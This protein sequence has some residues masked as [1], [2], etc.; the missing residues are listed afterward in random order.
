MMW[1]D[2][3]AIFDKSF[4][5]V[6]YFAFPKFCTFRFYADLMIEVSFFLK[7]VFESICKMSAIFFRW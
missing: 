5:K 4:P 3:K 1:N 7:N 2:L 6:C